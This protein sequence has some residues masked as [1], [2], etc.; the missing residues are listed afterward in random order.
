MLGGAV[1]SI[2]YTVSAVLLAS[3]FLVPSA[4]AAGKVVHR[5]TKVKGVLVDQYAWPD[6]KGL[7]RTVSLKREGGGNPGH[8]G[9]AVQMTYEVREGGKTRTV[10]AD[11][12]KGNDGGFGYFVSHERYRDFTDGRYGTIAQTIFKTDDSP[13]GNKF[14]VKGKSKIGPKSRS[15][16][17]TFRLDYPRYGT[18]APIAWNANGQQ[19]SDT[20][21]DQGQLKRYTLRVTM[22]W[23]FEAGTDFPRIDTSVD[24]A[25]VGQADRVNFDLRAPYGVLVFDDNADKVVRKVMWGDR[26]H[27]ETTDSPPT[28]ASGFVWNK[29]N[30]GSRYTALIAGTYEMGIYE[31]KPFKKSDTADGYSDARGKTSAAYACGDLAGQVLP[32]DWEWPYQSL[33]YSL[34]YDD[35]NQPTDGKKIAWGSAAYY[36]AGDSLTRSYDTPNSFQDI[37]GFPGSKT[38]RYSTCIVL[39]KTIKGGLT[40]AAAA[41]NSDY[42][43]AGA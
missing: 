29:P 39:G 37:V 11:A 7:K 21:V 23:I 24:M 20:P 41:K 5:Q 35:V 34:P 3:L 6:S 43:C 42:S 16:T 26:F 25:D 30:K 31:P 36:G 27:F 9:Y 1:S 12:G 22:V 28:R 15:A 10:V 18:I 33:Q 13:L 32:C 17:H 4:E 40:R 38:I 14:P 2:P 8:G 19:V